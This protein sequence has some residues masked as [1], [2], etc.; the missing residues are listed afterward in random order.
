MRKFFFIFL[1]LTGKQVF[2]QDSLSLPYTDISGIRFTDTLT[3]DVA[4]AYV[5]TDSSLEKYYKN[6]HFIAGKQYRGIPACV[7]P[8]NVIVKFKIWNSADS[9]RNIFFF[10]GFFFDNIK[11][12]REETS[13]LA[14]IPRILPRHP[15]SLGYR[16]ISLAPHDSATVFA[17]IHQ[18]RTY[19]NNLFPRLINTFYLPAYIVDLHHRQES[20]DLTTYVFTGLLLMMILFSLANYAQGGNREFLYYS[21]YAF[22][23]AAMFFTK[24][25]YNQHASFINYFIEGY[26]DFILQSLGIGFYMVFMQRFLETRKKYPFLH[27]LYNVGIIVLAVSVFSYSYLHFFAKNYAVQYYVETITK[28][29]LIMMIVVFAWYSVK[30][31]N[32]KLLRFLVW[33]NLALFVFSLVSQAFIFFKWKFPLPPIFNAALFYY[34]LGLF[35][36]LVFFLMG[37]SYK[38]RKQ[39]IEQ[40]KERERLK[41][42]NERKE[43][44]KQ[45]AVVTAQQEER[46]R[47]STD[48]HDELG[49]GMTAI[50]LMSE[51]AK[52]K[53]KENTPVEIERISQ[54]AD[55]VL[56]KMNAIIWSMNSRN[57]SL[58][59]LISYIRSYS[60]EYLEGTKVDCKVNI[61]ENIPEKE[62]T[63]DKRRNIF[64]CVKETLNNM[65][66]HSKATELIIDIAADKAL[67]I[68]IHDNGVGID[69]QKIREFGTGLQNIDRRM[70]IIGGSFSI[71]NRNGTVSI[72]KLEL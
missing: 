46:N 45:M 8:K 27:K 39:I 60:L 67:T 37:L 68:K 41:M 53:M 36:E 2:C 40:T 38:N 28:D 16:L 54:S 70:K 62:L 56:N 31:W 52:N 26:L 1:L 42:E 12:Y 14:A 35:L 63:G 25:F 49:S 59:N 50:R 4:T 6:F 5:S 19:N 55:D 10:P 64:L 29:L 22:F 33:G 23:L 61:P 51:I 11:L 47:I 30:R 18:V 72:L 58:G 15:D 69:L 57:D 9:T 48:M 17:E 43:F 24:S 3:N 34:E 13:G 21:G 65:L 7:V 44:E 32:D 20:L 66:K 71:E